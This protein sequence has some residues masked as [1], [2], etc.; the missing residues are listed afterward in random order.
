[1]AKWC[2]N[3]LLRQAVAKLTEQEQQEIPLSRCSHAAAKKHGLAIVLTGARRF[4][5]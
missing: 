4:R 5:H 1:M 2:L 3:F